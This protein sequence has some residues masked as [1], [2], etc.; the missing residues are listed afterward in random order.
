MS[1]TTKT[2]CNLENIKSIYILKQIFD[3]LQENIKLKI[4][5]YN[6]KTQKKLNISNQDYKEYQKIIIE[7]IP[8]INKCG[9]F[10]NMNNKEDVFYYHAYFNDNKE[11]VNMYYLNKDDKVRKI[12]LVIDY[13]I[14]SF[15][16][17]FFDCKCI[18]SIYF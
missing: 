17:L 1:K 11:E 16:K 2:K 3:N 12:K 6:I 13:Q 15:Y 14:R 5:K 8:A 10:F 4:V 9:R 7:I 18:E